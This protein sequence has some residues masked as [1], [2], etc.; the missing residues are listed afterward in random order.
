MP[1]GFSLAFAQE[2]DARGVSEHVRALAAWT[3][4]H[5]RLRI[6]TL[7]PTAHRAVAGRSPRQASH[8][9]QRLRQPQCL[10]QGQVKQAFDG[11][12]KRDGSI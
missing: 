4:V 9:V 3:V 11:Q 10:T 2:L 8:F 6:L 5:L 7:L 12:V 1:L